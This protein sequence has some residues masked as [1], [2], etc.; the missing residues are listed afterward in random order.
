MRYFLLKFSKKN[1]ELLGIVK[2]VFKNLR[3][4]SP[5]TVRQIFYQVISLTNSP[6]ENSKRDYGRLSRLLVKARYCGEISFNDIE[7]RTRPTS[8]RPIPLNEL[9]YYYYPEAW[10]NQPCYIEVFVE[11]EGLRA[12]FVRT[13]RPLYVAVTPMRGF[14]SLSNVMEAARRFHEY[15]NRPRYIF[16]FSDFDPSGECIFRDFE[17]RLKKCLVMLGEEP[18]SYDEDN[19]R[20]EIP[21]IQVEKVALTL[22]QVEEY[23]LPPKFVKPKDPRASDFIEKYGPKAV[24]E[25]DALPPKLLQ[26]IILETIIPYLDIDEVER[27]RNI[28]RKVKTEGLEALQSLV[29]LEDS[30]EDIGEDV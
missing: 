15:K 1:S 2:G 20:I 13:L 18:I 7:D 12:F 5:L 10:T 27:V 11:K 17:Y 24:V 4:L 19:K 29:N 3:D 14:D 28:E 9:L 30:N 22:E 21:N 25:L 16:I 26:E 8:N 6:L 23:G